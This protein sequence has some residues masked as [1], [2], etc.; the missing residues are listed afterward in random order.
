MG[1]DRSGHLAHAA[2]CAPGPALPRQKLTR[3]EMPQS[4]VPGI[5]AGKLIEG[6]L[7]DRLERGW[8]MRY[9]RSSGRPN[10][11]IRGYL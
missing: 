2:L 4:R 7:S 6:D 1:Y 10:S 8:I 3:P 5:E 9:R 11:Y